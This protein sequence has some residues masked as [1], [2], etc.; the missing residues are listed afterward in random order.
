MSSGNDSTKL[1]KLKREKKNLVDKRTKL[2]AQYNHLQSLIV[3]LDMQ[4]RNID[5]QI[6]GN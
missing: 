1:I 4:I 2:I 6:N 3:S 5:I